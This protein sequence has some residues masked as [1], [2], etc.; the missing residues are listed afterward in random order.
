M[1]E[2]LAAVRTLV[3]LFPRR[4]SDVVWIVVDVFVAL[5]QLLLPERL[6]AELTLI[7]LLVRVDQHVRLEMARRD[8]R[9][10][11][12]LAAVALF[13][14]VRLCVDLVGVAIG[15][16]AVA[17]TTLDRL[18]GGVELL[19][20]DSKIGFTTARRRTELTLE[21]RL[22]A[23][24]VDH[25][26]GLERIGLGEAR[27]ADVTWKGRKI[28]FA[29][30]RWQ[31]QLTLIRLLARVDAEM[32]LELEG[33]WRSVS[34]VRTLIRSFPSVTADVPLQFAEL[35]TCVVALGTLVGLLVRVLVASVTNQLS[36]SRECR[37]AELA[38]MWFRARVGVDVVCEA[39]DGFE[40]ALANVAL[41]GAE[42]V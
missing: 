26:V 38:L 37:V 19:H 10:G 17:A 15:E 21:N 2:C 1:P 3:C 28:R 31:R 34:A 32:P 27:L 18:V 36:G 6:F 14:F 39:G 41:V 11:A 24:R 16:F 20:V 22:F 12:K 30:E 23:D 13:T 42:R 33:V 35:N 4:Q 25:L 29:S 40:A 7:G 5:Q 9:V 8:R